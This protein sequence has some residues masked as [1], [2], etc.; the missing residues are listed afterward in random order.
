MKSTEDLRSSLAELSKTMEQF[1][2]A[3]TMNSI[4]DENKTDIRGAVT[5]FNK[6]SGNFSKISDSLN[7]GLGQNS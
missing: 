3:L 7:K 2:S 6:I 5:N 4:L 1:H